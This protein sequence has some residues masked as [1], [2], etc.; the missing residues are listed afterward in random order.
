MDGTDSRAGNSSKSSME[1]AEENSRSARE[2]GKRSTTIYRRSR[3]SISGS[4][5]NDGIADAP[6]VKIES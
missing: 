5:W 6:S 1:A 4:Y 3:S 2:Y